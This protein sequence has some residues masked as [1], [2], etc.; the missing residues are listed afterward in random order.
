MLVNINE[1]INLMRLLI[2]L[3]LLFNLGGNVALDASENSIN[4]ESSDKLW[5]FVNPNVLAKRLEGDHAHI[6][7]HRG[8]TAGQIA[9]GKGKFL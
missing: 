1:P 2:L 6:H 3:F 7:Q 4:V 5:S 8:P 9:D